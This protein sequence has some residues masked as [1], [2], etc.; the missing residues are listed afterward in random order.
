MD[1]AAMKLGLLLSSAF[2]IFFGI[3]ILNSNLFSKIDRTRFRRRIGDFNRLLFVRD[4]PTSVYWGVVSL[5]I[6]LV[7]FVVLAHYQR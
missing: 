1:S 2:F 7:L 5:A 6:G 3:H 4:R